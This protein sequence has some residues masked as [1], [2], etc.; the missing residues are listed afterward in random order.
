MKDK[1][2]YQI[3]TRIEM[4]KSYIRLGEYMLKSALSIAILVPMI[5]ITQQLIKGEDVDILT[6]SFLGSMSSGTYFFF[7]C[8]IGAIVYLS[9]RFKEAGVLILDSAYSD[10]GEHNKCEHADPVKASSAPLR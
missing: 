4:G 5:A 8:S 3:G 6:L 1:S 9:V 10:E 2:K 7:F